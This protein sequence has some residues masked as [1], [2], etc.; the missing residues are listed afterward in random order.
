M[1]R[2]PKNR[3]FGAGNGKHLPCSV[4]YE[5]AAKAEISPHINIGKIC[6]LQNGIKISFVKLVK[7]KLA[8]SLI[9]ITNWLDIK[10]VLKYVSNT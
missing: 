4:V 10:S 7:H 5:G 6:D 3:Y 1:I 2:N 8:V 9:M